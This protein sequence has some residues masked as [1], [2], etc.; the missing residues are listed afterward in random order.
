M[1]VVLCDQSGCSRKALYNKEGSGVAGFTLIELM[2][3]V[4]VVAILAA[5][6]IPSYQDQVRKSRRAQVKADLV[7][8]GQ[9]LERWRT[10]KNTYSG[11][12]PGV[13]A[14]SPRTGTAQ[15]TI[16]LTAQTSGTYLLTATPTATSGQNNDTCGVLTLNQ[17]GAKTSKGAVNPA[18]F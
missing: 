2:I 7:E 14:Q 4:A 18:C 1:N 17:A 3:T 12:V 9:V 8:S 15:Y 6:A 11:T 5:I 16:A 13:L 10:V